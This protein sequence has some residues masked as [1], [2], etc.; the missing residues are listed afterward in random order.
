MCVFICFHMFPSWTPSVCSGSNGGCTYGLSSAS[1][2]VRPQNIRRS[3]L[4]DEGVSE[5]VASRGQRGRARRQCREC[6]APTVAAT[7]A[8]R[9]ALHPPAMLWGRKRQPRQLR[10]GK[11][12]ATTDCLGYQRCGRQQRC[13]RQACVWL[14]LAGDA[15]KPTGASRLRNKASMLE[16]RRPM[17]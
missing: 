4:R 17:P 10:G 2:A 11:A 13:E 16:R 7:A 9:S 12:T 3:L 6:Q 14:C 8:A 1:N 15:P 5:V